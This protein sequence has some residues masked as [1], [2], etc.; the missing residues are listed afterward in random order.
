MSP[1]HECEDKLLPLRRTQNAIQTPM[2]RL[3][4]LPT[5]Q[6]FLPPLSFPKRPS[7]PDQGI[8][9][10]ENLTRQERRLPSRLVD[11]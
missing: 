2:E 11:F 6:S 4:K 7:T 3:S 5:R 1:G 8:A 10:G 9:H